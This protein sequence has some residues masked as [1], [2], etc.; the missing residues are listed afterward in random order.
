MTYTIYK[1]FSNRWFPWLQDDWEVA[2]KCKDLDAVSD[3]YNDIKQNPSSGAYEYR[4]E[5]NK[6]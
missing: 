2:C 3:Y 4:V 6:A 5:E 1:R